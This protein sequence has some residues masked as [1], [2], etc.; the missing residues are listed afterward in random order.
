MVEHGT[1]GF[2]ELQEEVL[3]DARKLYSEKTID[4]AMNPWNVGDLPDT[5]GL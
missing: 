4:H 1:S 2:E 3:A 5:D